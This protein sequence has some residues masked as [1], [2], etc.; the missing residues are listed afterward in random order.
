MPIDTVELAKALLGL[1]L[2]RSS[3]QGRT[4]GRIVEVE[5]Y[6]QNDPASHAF[7][8]LTPRNAPMFAAPHRAYVYFI[9]GNH[10]CVNVTSE[11][12]GTP[13][14]VLIRALEP[15]EG[16]PLMRQRRGIDDDVR[17]C[18]GPGRLCQALEIDGSFNGADLLVGPN[19]YLS[20]STT[21]P[22]RIRSSPRIG[23]RKAPTK[24]L[25]FYEAANTYVSG[26]AR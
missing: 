21:P 18:R 13:G 23:I 9:Y 10:W 25:R 3:P 15:L 12:D 24:R 2:V 1:C 17:L 20:K 26:P 6:L 7:R 5:A 16:L 8:R 4:A 11:C 14:A 22:A 19:L